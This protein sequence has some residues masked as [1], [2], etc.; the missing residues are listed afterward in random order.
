MDY[1]RTTLSK[2]A[3]S[4]VACVPY[5]GIDDKSFESVE[6]FKVLGITVTNQNSIQEEIKGK[7]ISGKACQPSVQN[8]S[9]LVCYPKI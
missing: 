9:L 5:I 7:L 6:Q 4:A 8:L 3:F 2:N 1:K